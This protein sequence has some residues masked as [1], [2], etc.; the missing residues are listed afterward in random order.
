MG[1]VVG[2]TISTQ[3]DLNG[4][5]WFEGSA[6]NQRYAN[7]IIVAGMLIY[8]PPVSYT[9][10]NSGPTTCVDLQTGEVLWSRS[11]VPAIS[12]AS[13]YDVEDPQQHGVYPAILYTS[14]FGHAYDAYTGELLI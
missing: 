5:T 14:N 2:G 9:G 11:D 1:G 6:Y 13:I 10:S 3:E 12:F 7:P 4:N 8:N